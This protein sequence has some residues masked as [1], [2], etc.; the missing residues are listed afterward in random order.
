MG[1]EIDIEKNYMRYKWYLKSYVNREGIDK[2]IEY[3]D[4]SDAM[5]CPA[6]TKYHL[7]CEGG[8]V[9]H[10]INVFNRLFK[11]LKNEYGD[12]LPYSKE[13]IALVA[14]LHDISKTNYYKVSTRNVKDENGK[15]TSVE[16]YSVREDDEKLVYGTHEENS[17]E[18]LS[19][20]IPLTYEERVSILYHM[21]SNSEA[22]DAYHEARKMTAYKKVPLA[23]WLH[24]AD[25][26]ATC[27]D[28]V[29]GN[30]EVEKV[31]QNNQQAVGNTEEQVP[32]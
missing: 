12:N 27:I 29:E 28:E 9:Q 4:S 32:V 25:M 30:S 6:S 20:F 7:S 17:I 10:S 11:L 5:R 26:L 1:K 18:I 19:Q 3:L 31:E 2:L 8:F 13:S 16:Y 23:V 24:M 22:A 21:G 14:L 15:W